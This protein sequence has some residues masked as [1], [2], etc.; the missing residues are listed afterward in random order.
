M[1]RRRLDESDYYPTKSD[2]EFIKTGCTTLDCVLGGGW[3][4]GRITN[5]VGDKAVGKTLLAI[6]GSANFSR[7]WPE[8][9]IKYREAEAAFDKP[10]AGRLGLP[11]DKVDF[12]PDDIATQWETIEEISADL[13]LSIEEAADRKQ[14]CLYI[15]DSL[16]AISSIA[17][18]ERDFE[19]GSYGLEKQKGLGKIFRTRARTLKKHRVTLIIISQVRSKIGVTFGEKLT[20]TGGLAMDFYA[21][22]ALW[23][24]SLG[25]EYKTVKGIKRPYA[26]N[27]KARCKKNKVA[28]PFRQCEFPIEFGY[29][30][31][32]L[33]ACVKFLTQAK[34][35]D[36]LDGYDKSFI[37]RV[38]AMDN[39]NYKKQMIAVRKATRLTWREVEEGFAPTRSK[40]A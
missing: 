15:L 40:Y 27:I 9:K 5:I 35:T 23:L 3:P 7:Q 26:L 25:M 12:G 13:D 14:P 24:S 11:L 39:A 34:A 18:L 10:Y 19:K 6:E 4:V 22:I 1:A 28:M 16:D 20:R 29:G 8:G 21:S 2:L 30:I 32:E 33:T 17:E 31:D 37:A 36:Q 38:K